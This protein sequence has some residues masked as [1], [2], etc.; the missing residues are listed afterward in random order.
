MTLPFKRETGPEF[1]FRISLFRKLV[2]DL[3][4]EIPAA[5]K[6]DGSDDRRLPVKKKL[7]LVIGVI[8][9]SFLLFDLNLPAA[10]NSRNSYPFVFML[11]IVVGQLTL[12]CVWGTL[13]E[14]TFWIRL[15][16]TI[17]MLVISWA[18][19]ARGVY[20]AN[21][22]TN[23]AEVLGLG[24]VWFYAFAISYIPLKVA[25]WG[26]GWRILKEGQKDT[27]ES[28]TNYQIRDMMI[29]TAILAVT[30]TIGRLLLPGDLPSWKEVI[31]TSGLNDPQPL[32]AMFIFSVVSLIVKLPCIWIALAIPLSKVKRYSIYWIGIAAALGL[33]EIAL[34]TI[35]LGANTD[36]L[37]VTISLMLGH[38]AMAA[39]MIGVL[40]LL[41]SFGYR[42]SRRK[43]LAAA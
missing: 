30:L 14:G 11:N 6:P 23:P 27:L 12:I 36:M 39:I 32:T 18:V 8:F 3:Q 15:P 31:S 43:R 19:L 2:V 16:W 5:D 13:V 42:M 9:A 1:S 21:G 37:E 22:S 41:R 17:L 29:G 25:A 20:L 24:L 40:Y 35:A 28:K 4:S 38:A 33:F 34:L 7:L 10:F 26:F